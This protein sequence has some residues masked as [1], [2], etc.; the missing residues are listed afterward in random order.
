MAWYEAIVGLTGLAFGSYALI[1]SVPAVVMSA[2]VSLGSFKHIIYI[3][4]QLAK[5]LNKYYDDKGYMRPQYQMS[6][7]IGS[8]CFYYWVKYPFI[9]HRVTTDSKKFK[10]FMWVNA[11]GMWS[12]I[13]LIVSLIFLKFT[14]YMP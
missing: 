5:D 6:W 9:R 13:I 1:W 3:D 10:I 2:I 7:A 4:K 8:R 12:Y 11:L 14:G